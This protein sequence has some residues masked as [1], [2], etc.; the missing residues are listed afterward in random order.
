MKEE[1]KL[2]HVAAHRLIT[3]HTKGCWLNNPDGLK[4]NNLDHPWCTQIISRSYQG[5][6]FG[7]VY[8]KRPNN[9]TWHVIPCS[10]PD[11]NGELAI[12]LV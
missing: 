9:Y 11:C 4:I 2:I 6:W 3:P 8:N 1:N 10:M 12:R 7:T 5:S